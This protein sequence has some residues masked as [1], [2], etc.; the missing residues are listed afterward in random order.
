MSDVLD[1]SALQKL[2]SII[3]GDPEDLAEL[4]G[5][6]RTEVPNQLQQMRDYSKSGDLTS[7]RLVAHNC[8]SNARDLGALQLSTLCAQLE[9]ESATGKV[10]NLTEQLSQ[11]TVAAEAALKSLA[12]LDLKD[13]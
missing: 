5:D 3:G 7:L 2:K 12:E 6:L 11:I 8:K 9:N 13:V 1:L 4:V 10:A